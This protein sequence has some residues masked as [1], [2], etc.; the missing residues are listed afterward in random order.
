MTLTPLQHTFTVLGFNVDE[1][2]YCKHIIATT[3]EEAMFYIFHQPIDDES[4]QPRPSTIIAVFQ[5]SYV[6]CG[7][8]PNGHTW[9]IDEAGV[10]FLINLKKQIG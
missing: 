2:I 9:M 8:L 5:G 3:P 10:A 4:N 6:D 1:S 7:L